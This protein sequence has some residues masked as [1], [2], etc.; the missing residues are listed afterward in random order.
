MST[1]LGRTP[2][3]R[4]TV[5]HFFWYSIYNDVRDYIKKCDCCQTRSRLPPN[6]KNLAVAMFLYKLRC[7]H[8]CLEV[9]INDQGRQFVSGV[10]T[11][12]HDLTGVEQ[13]IT[14]AYYL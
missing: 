3:Y 1:H 12:L 2:T 5:A 6:A 7:C 14:S 13:R 11:C 10:C 4:K 9:Q 8:V